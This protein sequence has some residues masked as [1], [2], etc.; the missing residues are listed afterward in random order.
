[1]EMNLYDFIISA[2]FEDRRGDGVETV[3]Q[4][5]NIRAAELGRKFAHLRSDDQEV[6]EN[7]EVG[8]PYYG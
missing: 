7:R 2:P 1:M 4:L 6:V 8:H 3:T 5:L